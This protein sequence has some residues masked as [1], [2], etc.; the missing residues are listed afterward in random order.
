MTTSCTMS[1]TTASG[2][3][4]DELARLIA[5]RAKQLGELTEDATIAA[6]IDVLVSLRSATLDARK[7]KNVKPTIKA[8]A[9]LRLSFRREGGKSRPCLRSGENGPR[10]D[11]VYFR[12][13]DRYRS[14]PARMF[15]IFHITPEHTAS[16][17]P[18]YLA[19]SSKA[20]A[21]EF[22]KIR[23]GKRIEEKGGLAKAALGI[24]MAKLSTRNNPD[25]AGYKARVLASNLSH[26]VVNNSGFGSGS[27]SIEYRDDL[28]YSIAALR[29]GSGAV[30]LAV[31]KAAN[32]I[33]GMITHAAHKAGDFEHDVA[34]PFPDIVKRKSK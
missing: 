4:M 6:A 5:L 12:I 31:Q 26:V 11:G 34:S 19:T 9:D 8:R 28:D 13:D 3:S 30:D 1:C 14:I 25:D 27:F 10:L 2:K 16:C 15:H 24:A 29:G 32:K 18:Y 20:A 17:K 22:E 21:K 23:A 7:H 33:A